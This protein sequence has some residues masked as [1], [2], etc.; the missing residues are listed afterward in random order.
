MCY[1]ACDSHRETTVLTEL[2][3]SENIV[4]WKPTPGYENQVKWMLKDGIFKGSN[5]WIGF[6][7]VYDD[8]CFE[9]DILLEGKSEGGIVIRGDYNSREPWNSGY[10]LDIDRTSD[11]K[12]GNVRF[13]HPEHATEQ[14]AFP[15]NEWHTVRIE[16]KG[17]TIT[18]YL[19]GRKV[20]N[21]SDTQFSSGTICL[22]GHA[23]GVQYRNARI[24]R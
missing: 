14:G 18:V 12:Q 2:F 11:G 3:D 10:E 13:W 9:T 21:F 7:E 20:I 5:S 4:R 16:A 1:S 6:P 15:L 24:G 22:E 17:N 23:G 8:F 19:D